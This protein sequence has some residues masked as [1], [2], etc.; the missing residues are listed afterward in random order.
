M[1]TMKV[2][3]MICAIAGLTLSFPNAL[4]HWNWSV[5]AVGAMV[6]TILW[7]LMTWD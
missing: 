6:V 7:S 1:N 2:I 4:Q 3:G 5:F